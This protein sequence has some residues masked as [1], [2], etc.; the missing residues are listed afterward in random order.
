[1]R[2]LSDN[3]RAELLSWAIALFA[4]ACLC[5]GCGA[6][7]TP[8]PAG[9]RHGL[10]VRPG[11]NET[12]VMRGCL[13]W[14]LEDC[15][16]AASIETA[17]IVV[18]PGREPDCEPDVHGDLWIGSGGPGWISL[19]VICWPQVTGEVDQFVNMAATVAHEI[20]HTLGIVNHVADPTAVMYWHVG[21]TLELTAADRAALAEVAA[22]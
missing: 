4:V 20:G 3:A 12:A 5:L 11:V 21:E 8:V 18:S 1:M 17:R 7:W 15:A 22:K 2:S 10:W 16:P 6:D 14:E 9:S 13:V 19:R